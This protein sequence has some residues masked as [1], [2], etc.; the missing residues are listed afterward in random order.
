M[1]I[2]SAVTAAGFLFA[3]ASVLHPDTANA[4]P[5]CNVPNCTQLSGTYTRAQIKS[6]CD[7]AGG[8]DT[9]TSAE[10]GGYGCYVTEGDGAFV[11]CD[12]DG[13]CI[14]STDKRRRTAKV[15]RRLEDVFNRSAV[16]PRG[17]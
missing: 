16:T 1:R 3:T 17:R 9:G 8:I 2:L 12:A 13:T 15:P 14:G 4:A 11:E 7:Q 5:K 10:S 6:Y